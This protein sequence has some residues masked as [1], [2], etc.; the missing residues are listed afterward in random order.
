MSIVVGVK[1][2]HHSLVLWMICCCTL[3]VT[4]KSCNVSARLGSQKKIVMDNL[5]C[6]MIRDFSGYL[7]IFMK[8]W[9]LMEAERHKL[10]IELA[11]YSRGSGVSRI[12]TRGVH[13]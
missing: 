11:L 1:T 2:L 10:G 7:R 13:G 5:Y 4:L 9:N 12:G 3:L 8:L 6:R